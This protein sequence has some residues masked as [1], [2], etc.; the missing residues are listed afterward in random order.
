MAA[1]PQEYVTAEGLMNQAKDLLSAIP[2]AT[3]A[4]QAIVPAKVFIAHA[5][6]IVAAIPGAGESGGLRQQIYKLVQSQM[7]SDNAAF[8]KELKC[9]I[10]LGTL[11]DAGSPPVTLPCGHS[12]CAAC[13]TP[14]INNPSPANRRCPSC[15]APITIAVADL[16]TNVA[17]Q[18]IVRRILPAAGAG[19]AVGGKRNQRN[20]RKTR[21][22]KKNMRKH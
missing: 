4:E 14:V 5:A 11:G 19:A 15:R 22:S 9:P 3:P 16:R 8:Y 12:F 7:G 10:H 13:I 2:A 1:P 21:R 6:S 17:I 20:Q 18:D